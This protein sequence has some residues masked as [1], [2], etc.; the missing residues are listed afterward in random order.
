MSRGGAVLHHIQVRERIH[1]KKEKYPNPNPFKRFIDKAIYFVGLAAVIISIPQLLQIWIGKDATGVSFI[2]WFAYLFIEIL[3]ITYGFIHK[4][5]PI[6]LAYISIF[7]V[8]T[9]I[10]IGIVLYN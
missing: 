1:V 4:L 2:T 9:L 10:V 8:D 6:I 5:K 3:W 7:I